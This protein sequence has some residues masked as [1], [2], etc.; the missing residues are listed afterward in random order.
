MKFRHALW[1]NTKLVA[2]I[3]GIVVVFLLLATLPVLV[4]DI[5]GFW[6]AVGVCVLYLLI[7]V[8]GS[9]YAE[10]ATSNNVHR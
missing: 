4:S 5:F 7:L 3:I 2:A 9:S 8:V 6:P 1:R 10:W